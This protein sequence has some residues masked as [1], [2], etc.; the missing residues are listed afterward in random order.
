MALYQTIRNNDWSLAL[1]KVEESVEELLQITLPSVKLKAEIDSFSRENRKIEKL[2]ATHLANT[3]CLRSV[4][5]GYYSSGAPFIV[6]SDMKISITHTQGWVA[7]QISTQFQPGIDIE[8]KSDRILRIAH[9]FVSTSELNYVEENNKVDYFNI[10]WCSKE[11]LFKV[12]QREG[13]DFIE[14]L[15]VSSFTL[16]NGGRVKGTCRFNAFEDGYLLEY[17][18]TDD[19][20]LVYRVK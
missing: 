3:L 18:I 10:I 12:A 6:D 4:E 17:L 1:W 5:I 15:L 9:K 16:S 13:V 19:W 11:V 14:N 8:Y 2:V 7:V 20:Y